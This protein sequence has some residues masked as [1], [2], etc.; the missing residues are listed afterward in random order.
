MRTA[1]LFLLIGLV[2]SEP[3]LQQGLPPP[4]APAPVRVTDP[5]RPD[6][7][8]RPWAGSEVTVV[9]VFSAECPD[10]VASIPF[11]RRVQQRIGANT[12][13]RSLAFLTEDGLWPAVEALKKEGLDPGRVSSYPRDDRFELKGMPTVLLF[14][15]GWQR[16]GE[17]HG[18]LDAAGEREVLAAI[19]RVIGAT[20][21]S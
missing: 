2:S 10:C 9:V 4:D 17:W 12:N 14:G 20:K 18:R 3:A 5:A 19:D 16:V 8:S 21:E 1:A 13:R 15:D 7:G 6:F 11:Y